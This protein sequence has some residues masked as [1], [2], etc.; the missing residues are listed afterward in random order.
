MHLNHSKNRFSRNTLFQSLHKIPSFRR[1]RFSR[2][3]GRGLPPCPIPPKFPSPPR[4]PSPDS[5]LVQTL[6][7]SHFSPFHQGIPI[8]PHFSTNSPQLFH[9][10]RSPVS[11]QLVS[12]SEFPHVE[13]PSHVVPLLWFQH[14][15]HPP[16]SAITTM[17]AIPAV[18][19]F[20]K[21]SDRLNFQHVRIFYHLR[22]SFL[23]SAHFHPTKS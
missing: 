10:S 15:G 3:L 16:I 14:D 2:D 5:S 12:D 6:R 7:P 8:F 23:V 22:S 13:I 4:I 20:Q 19:L 21:K 11:L 18:F 1:S 9:H 17:S